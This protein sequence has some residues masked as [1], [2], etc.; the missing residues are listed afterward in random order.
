MWS[1]LS[2]PREVI[3]KP[4]VCTE[5]LT[6]VGVRVQRPRVCTQ[7]RQL[8]E[9]KGGRGHRMCGSVRAPVN[10]AIGTRGF[11][12]DLE[13]WVTIERRTAV[14]RQSGVHLAAPHRGL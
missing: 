6:K 4:W 5:I 1:L 14:A 2:Q 9:L 12:R 10:R 7:S 13:P 3:G 8:A 11:L